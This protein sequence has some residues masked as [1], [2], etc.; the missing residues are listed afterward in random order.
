[1]KEDRRPGGGAGGGENIRKDIV[2]TQHVFNRKKGGSSMVI[3][4]QLRILAKALTLT[5]ALALALALI[6][7]CWLLA[8]GSG[9]WL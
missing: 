3:S 5:L 1:M 9:C 8:T 4:I 6:V 7:G 2:H